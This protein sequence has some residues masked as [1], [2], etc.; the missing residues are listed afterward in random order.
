MQREPTLI[1]ALAAT[2]VSA[3][4]P[5]RQ[6]VRKNTRKE[7]LTR[8]VLMTIF[9][10]GLMF[11][12]PLRIEA[13]FGDPDP[14]FGILQS[15]AISDYAFQY[16]AVSM[17]RQADGKILVTGRQYHTEDGTTTLVLRRYQ[18]NGI[19][20][21]SFGNN[22]TAIPYN[23]SGSGSNL[24]VQ[25]DGKIVVVG[26]GSTTGAV[27]RFNS[28]GWY[29]SSFGIFGRVLLSG[30]DPVG[31]VTYQPLGAASPYLI[32]A[33]YNYPKSELYRFNSN[34]SLDTS[35]GTNGKV[36]TPIR[37]EAGAD[38]PLLMRQGS[39]YLIGSHW[40]DTYAAI[41]KYT[42]DGQLDESFGLGGVYSQDPIAS[43][44]CQSNFY[45]AYLSF[46]F[47]SDGGIV[48]AGTNFGQASAKGLLT[49]HLPAGDFDLSFNML[50]CNIPFIQF[51]H[52]IYGVKTLS[53]DRILYQKSSNAGLYLQRLTPDGSPDGSFQPSSTVED[54]LVQPDGKILV[55]GKSL[56][57]NT[58]RLSRYLP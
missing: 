58:V 29:D 53:D 20:D 15:G 11:Y 55:V 40:L 37:I 23:I 49:R 57:S 18:A 54:F 42:P 50:P 9:A 16:V 45:S 21:S 8:I 17:A 7:I 4:A 38:D 3:E 34:G 44:G 5:A 51:I 13:A 28:N 31:V 1:I 41:A 22:G 43:Y 52:P 47:Q 35:F 19:P 46:A 6:E 48:A 39:L 30:G 10:A 12:Q 33:T 14:A 25:R 2:L 26:I 32:V 56:G 24:L 27:W 36:T